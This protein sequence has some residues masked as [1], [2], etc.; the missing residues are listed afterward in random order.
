MLLPCQVSILLLFLLPQS[1]CCLDYFIFE[2]FLTPV[3]LFLFLDDLIQ[4]TWL[5][6]Y[7]LVSWNCVP[8]SEFLPWTFSD[9]ISRMSHQIAQKEISCVPSLQLLSPL[10]CPRSVK[11]ASWPVSFL[12][13]LLHHHIPPSSLSILLCCLFF[14]A[15][16][17][18][19]LLL[20]TCQTFKLGKRKNLLCVGLFHKGGNDHLLFFMSALLHTLC[21]HS[22][23]Y[24][25]CI[26]FFAW[27]SFS[28][29]STLTARLTPL[30]F[31][32]LLLV[33]G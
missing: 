31:I 17:P 11:G 10:V 6:L 20:N 22:V 28:F 18:S 1:T 8:N 33:I 9:S 24:V 12:L 7:T 29:L 14:L 15:G 21:C 4:L 5:L 13:L 25:D 3:T 26:Y 32:C 30:V 16:T 19:F 2:L 27:P 23:Q